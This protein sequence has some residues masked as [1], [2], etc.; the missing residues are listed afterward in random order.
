MFDVLYYVQSIVQ[1][2]KQKFRRKPGYV[3]IAVDMG[4]RMESRMAEA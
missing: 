4:L 3:K 2:F 1:S